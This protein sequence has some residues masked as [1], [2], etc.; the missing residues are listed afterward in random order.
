MPGLLLRRWLRLGCN[1]PLV[2][3]VLLLR[4]LACWGALD[5]SPCVRE[6]HGGCAC[7]L[8]DSVGVPYGSPFLSNFVSCS[9]ISSCSSHPLWVLCSV[10]CLASLA[11]GW[12]CF[13]PAVST[14]PVCC[15]VCCLSCPSWLVLLLRSLLVLH[16]ILR[17][18]GLVTRLWPLLLLLCVGLLWGLC[19]TVLS[20]WAL[21]RPTLSSLRLWIP[22]VSWSQLLVFSWPLYYDSFL[23]LPLVMDGSGWLLPALRAGSPTSGW[24]CVLR[25]ALVL[26]AVPP[27]LRSALRVRTGF[28]F[29]GPGVRVGFPSFL[30]CFPSGCGHPLGQ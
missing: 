26:V 18:D 16:L 5:S 25:H 13:W 4:R 15:G 6:P 24:R 22:M 7:S 27:S 12:V 3:S 1:P 30:L 9:V 29:S 28:L 19:C 11:L 23:S 20:P 8:G 2:F 21:V 14:A 17:W 10:H